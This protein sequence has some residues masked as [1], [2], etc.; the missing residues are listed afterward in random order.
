VSDHRQVIQKPIITEKANALREGNKYVFR[1]DRKANKIQIRRAVEV[2]F[3]VHVVSVR[4]VSVPG[5]PKRQGMFPGRIPG[6]K[7][8]YVTLRAGESIE[9]V[10][11]V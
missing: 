10:E 2:I 6:W 4:T 5:K 9:A 1:V 11:N 8:A 3:N 7:K